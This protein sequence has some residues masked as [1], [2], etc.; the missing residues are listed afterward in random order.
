VIDINVADYYPEGVA[1][2]PATNLLYVGSFAT[3]AIWQADLSTGATRE[4]MGAFAAGGGLAGLKVAGGALWACVNPA[5]VSTQASALAQVDLSTGAVLATIPLELYTFC[6]DMTVTAA[7]DVYVTD[8]FQSLIFKVPAGGV[9][10]ERWFS[11]AAYA[12]AP[13]AFGFNGI[14]QTADGAGLLV[15]RFDT[16]ELLQIDI[17]GDG[18][19][20]MVTPQTLDT[21]IAYGGIDGLDWVDGALYAVRDYQLVQL[22]PDGT[23]WTSTPA[24]LSLDAATTFAADAARDLWVVES[25]FSKL[26][27]GDDSTN[28]TA[29]YRVVRY[30]P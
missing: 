26:F 1:I 2:D 29:P 10:A 15:G 22:T 6:N 5:D 18:T 25:Q 20:G 30:S 28:G 9:A 3:G 7:G 13:G 12:P 23:A 4:L 16:G 11:D 14:T 17:Q 27:D 21:A 19:A 8:S 24:A